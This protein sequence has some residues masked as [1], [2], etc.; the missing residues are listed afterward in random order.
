MKD[1]NKKKNEQL[2]M[3]HGTAA[4]RLRKAILFNLLQETGKDVC[5]QC[6]EKI[7]C[8]DHLSIEHKVPWLDSE[9]PIRLFFD[10]ENIAF[11]HLSCNIGARRCDKGPRVEHGTATR[12]QR[13]CRCNKCK[14]WKSQYLNGWR[15]DRIA[16]T[17]KR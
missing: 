1:N 12:Y 16:R 15:A 5:F 4:S 8:I 3:N 17:G 9:D 10:I 2:K 14:E 6:G 13:G 11:S 7:E